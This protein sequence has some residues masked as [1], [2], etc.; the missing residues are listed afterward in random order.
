MNDVLITGMTL[1]LERVARQVKATDLAERMGVS[2]AYLSTL[3]NR[4]AVK[5][6]KA[7]NY[8]KALA[9]FPAIPTAPEGQSAA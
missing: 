5:P 2:R 6:D 9:T 1:K 3:E 4:Y 7:E 8:R